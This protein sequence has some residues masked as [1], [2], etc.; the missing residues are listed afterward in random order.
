MVE[1]FTVGSDVERAQQDVSEVERAETAAEIA[2]IPEHE[3]CLDAEAFCLGAS[4]LDHDRAQI[5]PGISVSPSVPLLQI[6]CGARPQFEN[7]ADRGF[8]KF[9]N[10][11]FEEIDLV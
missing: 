5:E 8:G 4:E 1:E 11:G 10:R 3:A 2:H 9:R 6:G 7:A